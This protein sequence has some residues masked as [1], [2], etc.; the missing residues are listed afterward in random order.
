MKLGLGLGSHGASRLQSYRTWVELHG[1]VSEVG[2]GA[3][4]Q[5]SQLQ[6]KARSTPPFLC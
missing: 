5:Q 4:E 2:G 6:G 3:S 1:F